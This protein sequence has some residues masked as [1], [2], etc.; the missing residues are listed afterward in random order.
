MP[1]PARRIPL[2]PVIRPGVAAPDVPAVAANARVLARLNC[3][4]IASAVLLLGALAGMALL[5]AFQGVP[6]ATL[7][8][9]VLG[10]MVAIARLRPSTRT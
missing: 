9:P 1:N 10:V 3:R 5:V 7:V 4:V 6:L 8:P 2:H